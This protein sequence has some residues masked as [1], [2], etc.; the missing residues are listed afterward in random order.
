ME[1]RDNKIYSAQ[2]QTSLIIIIN[3]CLSSSFTAVNYTCFIQ[4]VLKGMIKVYIGGEISLQK[5]LDSVCNYTSLAINNISMYLMH[6]LINLW[7]E[8][9]I[10]Y[11]SDQLTKH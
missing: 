8:V 11:N 6:C 2:T 9:Y 5:F 10:Q 7:I 4:P 1:G 3:C